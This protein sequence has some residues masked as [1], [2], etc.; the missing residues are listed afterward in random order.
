MRVNVAIVWETAPLKGEIVVSNCKFIGGGISVGWGEFSDG[1]FSFSDRSTAKICFAIE[2]DNIDSSSQP[3]EVSVIDTECPFSF[4]ISDVIADELVSVNAPGVKAR[5]EQDILAALA[6]SSSEKNTEKQQKNGIEAFP[7]YKGFTDEQIKQFGPFKKR[8]VFKT[9]RHVYATP[10]MYDNVKVGDFYEID[11]TKGIELKADTGFITI[12]EEKPI[13]G[14][15][16]IGSGCKAKGYNICEWWDD[17]ESIDNMKNQLVKRQRIDDLNG[18][19]PSIYLQL[20]MGTFPGLTYKDVTPE[21]RNAVECLKKQSNG[22]YEGIHMGFY[23]NTAYFRVGP[24]Y[25][26]EVTIRG[27]CKI[28]EEPD[29]INERC[30]GDY[31]FRVIETTVIK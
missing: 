4:V 21:I 5:A 29:M 31:A 20:L 8:E 26:N 19:H 14:V 24:P 28:A 1:I 12:K 15:T 25:P 11:P 7:L 13:L 16:V 22:Y 10:F 18:I 30:P 9:Q 6:S 17:G 2:S 27:G 23:E 3:A